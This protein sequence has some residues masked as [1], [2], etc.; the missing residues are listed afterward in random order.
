MSKL[1]NMI[2]KLR[3]HVPQDTQCICI[4][5]TNTIQRFRT[6]IAVECKSY[7]KPT[8]TVNQILYFLISYQ[9]VNVNIEV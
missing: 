3:V 5:Y 9:V 4:T 2:M 6:T 8:D 7:S 1:E